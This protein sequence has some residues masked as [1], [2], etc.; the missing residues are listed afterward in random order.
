MSTMIKIRKKS[1]KAKYK[2]T[3]TSVE[4]FRVWGSALRAMGFDPTSNVP[5]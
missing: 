2:Y 5:G 4:R 1:Q 3:L